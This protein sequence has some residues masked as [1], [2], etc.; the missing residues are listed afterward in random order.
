M[1]NFDGLISILN[2]VDFSIVQ[3]FRAPGKEIRHSSFTDKYLAISAELV[4]GT[5]EALLVSYKL[6]DLLEGN[7]EPLVTLKGHY[8]YP[9]YEG[10]YLTVLEY[11]DP[12]PKGRKRK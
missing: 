9:E 12:N 7:L 4:E 6:A 5:D 10:D 11:K 2:K 3:Q 8:Y 1:V